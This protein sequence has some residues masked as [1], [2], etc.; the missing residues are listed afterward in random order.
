MLFKHIITDEDAIKRVT[1]NKGISKKEIERIDEYIKDG[2]HV[3]ILIFMNG[4]GPCE[5]TRPEWD[6]IEKALKNKHVK[7]DDV[8]IIDVN[9]DYLGEI[10]EVGSVDSYPTMKY[11]KDGKISDFDKG[12]RDVATFV[13]W[14]ESKIVNNSSS[15]DSSSQDRTYVESLSS[16][17]VHPYDIHPYVI[18]QG[19]KSCVSK[20]K[21]SCVRKAKKRCT[22]K[23][24]KKCVRKAKKRCSRKAKK[25]CS[26]KGKK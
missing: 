15:P 20:S 10:K 6:K 8:V 11:I 25:R 22:R 9:K 2:K 13:S 12:N 18:A 17:L 23:G 26:N 14:I 16:R 4:C 19:K 3:F 1:D 24:D 21:K 7:R 5:A